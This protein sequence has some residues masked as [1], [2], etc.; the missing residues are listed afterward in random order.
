MGHRHI[1]P[2]RKGIAERKAFSSWE[3]LHSLADDCEGICNLKGRPAA[4]RFAR[5]RV[6]SVSRLRFALET[7]D[8]LVR[9][10]ALHLISLRIQN[11]AVPTLCVVLAHDECPVVRHEA[12]F[13]LGQ[14]ADS[15]GVNSLIQAMLHDRDALVRHEAA[16][17]LGDMGAAGV[18]DALVTASEDVSDVVR[19]TAAM[20]GRQLAR[21]R[22]K[23]SPK[24]APRSSTPE[25]R[26]IRSR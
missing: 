5:A 3:W 10:Q 12:A 26:Q 19:R 20:A 25:R 4:A 9:R 16:E 6:K 1:A 23:S 22:R 18:S 24:H 7:G 13:C 15:R 8:A 14:L 21:I 11:R 17:A 2:E